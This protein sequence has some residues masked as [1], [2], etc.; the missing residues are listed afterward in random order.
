MLNH[1]Q[2]GAVLSKLRLNRLKEAITKKL[3]HAERS[4]MTSQI[5]SQKG[6]TLI[7]LM[8]VV[9]IIGILASVAIPQYQNYIARSDVAESVTSSTQGL[10]IALSEYAATY[11]N[12]VPVALPYSTLWEDVNYA[13]PD[14]SPYAPA[15]YALAGKVAT[16]TYTTTAYDATDPTLSAGSLVIAY[17][18]NNLN[19]DQRLYVFEIRINAAGTIQFLEND[20]VMPIADDGIHVK[21]EHRPKFVKL[22]EYT[23]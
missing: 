8:I 23:P 5:K 13:K 4:T 1:I 14:G 22:S 6:F 9:A 20:T 12:L 15:D 21:R 11:G 10:K 18:H 19:I 17:D 16:V 7:E 2:A 3:N